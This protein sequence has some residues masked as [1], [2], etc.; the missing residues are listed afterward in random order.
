M[1][2]ARYRVAADVWSVTSYKELYADATDCERY[3]R[4]HPAGS[5]R[6]SWLEQ[7]LSGSDAPCVLASDYVRAVPLSITRWLPGPAVALGT[8]GFGRSESRTALRRFF[9]VDAEHIV[10]AAL[11]ALARRGEVEAGTVEQAIRDFEIDP[12]SPNPVSV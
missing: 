4:L 10:V 5:P 7:N 6:E 3:N 11:G 9:E 1:L 12:D 8:D 2:E